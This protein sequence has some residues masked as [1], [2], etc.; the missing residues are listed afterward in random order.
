MSYKTI[1]AVMESPAQQAGFLDFTFEVV[2]SFDAH[3][4]GLHAEA[5]TPTPIVAPMEIPDPISIQSMQELAEKRSAEIGEIFRART[6]REGISCDWRNI[7]SASGFAGPSVVDSARAVDLIIAPQLASDAPGDIRTNFE[8]FLFESGRPVLMVPHVAKAAKPFS[9]VMVAWNGSREAARS[10]FD[11]LPFLKKADEVEIFSVNPR[12]SADE[13]SGLSGAE[14]AATLARHGINVVAT[15][16]H[17]DKARA[18]EIIEN[19]LS[20]N[21]VDLLVMGAYTHSRLWELLFGGVTRTLLG[22]MTAATLM[23]R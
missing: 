3:L 2:R 14:I 8:N 7:V 16:A 5:V 17:A 19:R 11:A 12:E 18:G 1:L 4:I 22:S 21:S 13:D 9:K 6:E 23:S 10:T 15:T 20:D